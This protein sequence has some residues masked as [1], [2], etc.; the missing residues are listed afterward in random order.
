MAVATIPLQVLAPAG[1]GV[2]DIQAA[3]TAF[4]S[5]AGARVQNDGRTTVILRNAGAGAHVVTVVTPKTVSGLAV[6]DKT[7]TIAAA[8]WAIL[9]FFDT[10]TFNE[11]S[12]TNSG[13]FVMTSDGTQTEMKASAFRS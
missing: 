13:Y 8:K 2:V 5:S 9:P 3:E 7:Y 4:D 11:Q 10:D 6:A 12:G 1:A